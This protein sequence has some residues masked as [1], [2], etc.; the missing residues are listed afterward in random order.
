[1]VTAIR[2]RTFRSFLFLLCLYFPGSHLHAQQNTFLFT[3][4]PYDGANFAFDPSKIVYGSTQEE[5]CAERSVWEITGGFT[6]PGSN[7]LIYFGMMPEGT[8]GA[9]APCCGFQWLNMVNGPPGIVINT[10]Q[11]AGTLA[12]CGETFPPTAPPPPSSLCSCPPG[13][14][15][16]PKDG[17]GPPTCGGGGGGGG[18]D[19]GGSPSSFCGNPVNAGTGNKRE[20][21]TDLTSAG[22]NPV[23]LVRNYNGSHPAYDHALGG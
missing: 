21:E 15:C 11:F 23:K 17:G 18:G 13:A 12:S 4:F 14:S 5:V 3:Y 1:M 7:A 10:P 2:V 6:A 16:S 8:C 9:N 22:V 19:G 20:S